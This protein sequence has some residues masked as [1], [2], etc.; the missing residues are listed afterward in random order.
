MKEY[1][2]RPDVVEKS[3]ARWA[4]RKADE[5]PEAAQAR[6]LAIKRAHAVRRYGITL[7]QRDEMLAAQGGLCALCKSEVAFRSNGGFDRA[8]AHIDHDHETG[9]VRG[10]LCGACNTALGRLGDSPE[11]I[12]LVL[13]Y[14]RGQDGTST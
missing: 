10:I 9:R 6:K 5:T 8:A 1:N 2:A 3:S 14:V 11:R 12:E 13:A 4:K 7:E